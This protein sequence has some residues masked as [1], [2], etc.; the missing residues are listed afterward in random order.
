MARVGRGYPIRPHLAVAILASSSNLAFADTPI[1]LLAGKGS[2]TAAISIVFVDVS[3]GTLLG[4]PPAVAT[5]GTV[6]ADAANGI[7]I[8]GGIHALSIGIT[9][10][11]VPTGTRLG[12]PSQAINTDLGIADSPFGIALG[13]PVSSVVAAIATWRL[14]NPSRIERQPLFG[15][16]T[17]KVTRESTVFGDDGGLFVSTEGDLFKGGGDAAG[18]IPFNTKYI[19]HGGCINT[20]RDA[21]I[22]ALWLANGFEV[23]AV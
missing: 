12:V 1:G 4:T 9:L 2:D 5:N 14:V 19:W 11:D 10:V 15:S 8:A 18:S 7:R 3:I 6:F 16:F 20:T 22:R 21:A 17:I 13:A 23:E